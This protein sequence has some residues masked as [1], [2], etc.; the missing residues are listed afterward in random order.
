[1]KDYDKIS[2]DVFEGNGVLILLFNREEYHSNEYLAES[3]S[4]GIVSIV[5]DFIVDYKVFSNLKRAEEYY[6]NFLAPKYEF[7]CFYDTKNTLIKQ[8]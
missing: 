5:T 4:R 1:M 8:L 7:I 6:R 3:L 2:K